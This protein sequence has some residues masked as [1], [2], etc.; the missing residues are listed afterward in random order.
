MKDVAALLIVMTLG[1]AWTL[2]F[3]VALDDSLRRRMWLNDCAKHRALAE[4][5]K[6]WPKVDA[7]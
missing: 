3:V 4:C 2:V 7:R 6:D 5:A 1:A